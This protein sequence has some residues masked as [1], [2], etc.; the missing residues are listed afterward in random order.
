MTAAACL[1]FHRPDGESPVATGR[2]FYR[3]WLDFTRF[4]LAGWPMAVLADVPAAAEALR[5][6]FPLPSGHRLINVLRVGTAPSIL[7]KYRLPASDIVLG[8]KP[9]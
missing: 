1:L 5:Q 3:F 9:A 6:R 4:G 8:G 2:A 7:P